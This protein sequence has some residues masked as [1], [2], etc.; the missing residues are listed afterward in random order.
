MFEDL[1]VRHSDWQDLVH[2]PGPSDEW[3]PWRWHQSADRWP[4]RSRVCALQK[5]IKEESSPGDVWPAWW[6]SR[7]QADAQT[8]TVYLNVD[9]V[10]EISV[11]VMSQFRF[12][13]IESLVVLSI[14]I[15]FLT[16]M[17]ISS[18]L[19][20]PAESWDLTAPAGGELLRL[21]SRL[22]CVIR[23]I[24]VIPSVF[25]ESQRDRCLN[26]SAT[27]SEVLRQLFADHH[28]FD[29]QAVLWIKL[30]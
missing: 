25:S 20:S 18:N 7:D 12:M 30:S 10:D 5:R 1:V 2:S 21:R 28:P 26:T 8:V 24:L 16:L 3:R 15:V 6:Q 27:V 13:I 19:Y 14:S 22:I 29:W 4:V 17:A 23:Q 11:R 9:C